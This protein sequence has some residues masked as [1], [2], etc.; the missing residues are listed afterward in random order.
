MQ[1]ASNSLDFMSLYYFTFELTIIKCTIEALSHQILNRMKRKIF[2][3]KAAFFGILI[4]NAIILVYLLLT[5]T[6]DKSLGYIILDGCNSSVKF[7]VDMCMYWQFISLLRYFVNMKQVRSRQYA[8]EFTLFNK[9]I[10]FWTIFL[11]LLCIYQSVTQFHSFVLRAYSE[12]YL[13]DPIFLGYMDF[14]FFIIFPLRDCF[15]ALSFAYLYYF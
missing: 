12:N 7:I 4:V 10:V 2:L 14:L 8:I 15:L 6:K 11:W 13:Q 3:I 9:F 5:Y 1:V